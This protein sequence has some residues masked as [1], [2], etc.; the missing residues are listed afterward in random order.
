MVDHRLIAGVPVPRRWPVPRSTRHLQ[1]RSAEGASQSRRHRA[2]SDPGSRRPVAPQETAGCSFLGVSWAQPPLTCRFPRFQV[3]WPGALRVRARGNAS[4]QPR[5]NPARTPRRTPPGSGGRHANA[6]PRTVP[7]GRQTTP[8][9]LA[10]VSRPT[11][12]AL[13]TQ[14]ALSLCAALATHL[15]LKVAVHLPLEY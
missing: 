7:A 6:P 1:A 11:P 5:C 15:P 14:T 2:P 12:R 8:T 13:P 4:F 3:S 9:R 10:K